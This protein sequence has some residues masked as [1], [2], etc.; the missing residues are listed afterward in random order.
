MNRKDRLLR[1]SFHL[2]TDIA[3]VPRRLATSFWYSPKS[4]RL[5]RRWS[6]RVSKLFG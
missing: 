6:P 2:F 5:L 4:K 3:S 1:L